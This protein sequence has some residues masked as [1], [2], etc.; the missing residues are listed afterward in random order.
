MRPLE[1]INGINSC[2]DR[3][4]SNLEMAM[5]CLSWNGYSTFGLFSQFE[6]RLLT[7]A[8]NTAVLENGILS[9]SITQKN[10]LKHFK[11]LRHDS[12]NKSLKW[13]NIKSRYYD[14]LKPTLNT[15]ELSEEFGRSKEYYMM[16]IRLVFQKEKNNAQ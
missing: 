7:P 13:K 9:D 11:R 8:K 15:Q 3:I 12:W 10:W 16:S 4:P 14:A 6:N 5:S 2:K 1:R